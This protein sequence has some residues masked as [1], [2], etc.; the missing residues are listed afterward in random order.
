[1]INI[2]VILAGGE[3]TR[4]R[5]VGFITPK[6]LLPVY[7]THLLNRQIEQARYAGVKRII[8]STHPDFFSKIAILSSK[9]VDVVSNQHHD[10]GAFAALANIISGK[11]LKESIFCSLADIYFIDNPFVKLG[12]ITETTLFFAKPLYE[13]ELAAGGI[14]FIDDGIVKK[15]VK[16]PIPNNSHGLR[17]NGLNVINRKSQNI[18]IGYI[19][20]IHEEFPPEDFFSYLLSSGEMIKCQ[21]SVDFVNNNTVNDLFLSGLYNFADSLISFEKNRVISIAE[22]FRKK[23]LI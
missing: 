7:N 5:D 8:V 3:S 16:P 14:G 15:I 21:N 13:Q 23:L 17:W 20:K 19:D 9:I 6:F 18:L 11:K 12:H 2:L 1:M 22:I 4:F 10:K